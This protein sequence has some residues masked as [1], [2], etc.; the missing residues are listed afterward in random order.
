MTGKAREKALKD[1]ASAITDEFFVASSLAIG[2]FFIR[3]ANEYGKSVKPQVVKILSGYYRDP[4]YNRVSNHWGFKI[5]YSDGE[6]IVLD[7]KTLHEYDKGQFGPRINEA[8]AVRTANRIPAALKKAI[9]SRS[10]RPDK[11]ISIR[12]LIKRAM[13]CLNQINQW[14]DNLHSLGNAH[15]YYIK[16]EALIELIETIDCGSV[17]GYANEG[18]IDKLKSQYDSLFA[19]WLYY[20]DIFVGPHPDPK[21]ISEYYSIEDL[22]KMFRR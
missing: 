14:R 7:D 5:A 9:I 8:E 12:V 11:N 21:E 10:V 4:I 22:K 18:K 17:G 6:K 13:E 20:Y 1:I 19:R 2:G 3:T 16:A 15:K